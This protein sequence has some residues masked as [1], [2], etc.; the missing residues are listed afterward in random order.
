MALSDW[1]VQPEDKIHLSLIIVRK[2]E[3]SGDCVVGDLV[4]KCFPMKLK[5]CWV[6][7][8]CIATPVKNCVREVERWVVGRRSGEKEKGK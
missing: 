1:R 3:E 5:K 2:K 8:D 4:V 6:C 7:L